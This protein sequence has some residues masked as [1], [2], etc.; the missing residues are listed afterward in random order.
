MNAKSQPNVVYY[1][2][3]CIYLLTSKESLLQQQKG[4][5]YIKNV[6][7]NDNGN[8]TCEAMDFDAS[9][10]IDLTKTLHLRVHCKYQS[11]TL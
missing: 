8:Y 4:T 1:S 7:R 2:H 3:S 5:L 9:E 6:T 11:Q 10:N